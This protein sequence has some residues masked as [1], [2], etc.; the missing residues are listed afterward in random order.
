MQAKIN[1]EKDISLYKHVYNYQ[2]EFSQVDSFRIVH[3]IQY[4]YF[5]EWARTKYL[6]AISRNID[7]GFFLR[8]YPVMT[9]HSE[10]DYIN[11]CR[12]N[13]KIEVLTRI[14]FVKNSSFRFE[15]IIRLE[16]GLP[17]ATAS[18]IL[19]NFNPKTAQAER[20]PDSLRK[21]ISDYEDENVI[22][23]EG[24]E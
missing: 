9:V 12:F 10:I 15:N 7:P 23:I 21:M 20:L 4:F 19:V 11:P 5:L 13:D 6:S 8:E 22:F 2:I 3:N 17:L 16:S 14:S 24:E 1:P 18:S